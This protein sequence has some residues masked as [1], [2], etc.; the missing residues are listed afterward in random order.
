MDPDP[1]GRKFVDPEHCY[2][3]AKAFLKA[4][5]QFYGLILV[6]SYAPGSG[7]RRAKSVRIRI[8]DTEFIR[9]KGLLV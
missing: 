8:H 5:N 6:N 4:G 2:E 9:S 7:S 1:E 3:D